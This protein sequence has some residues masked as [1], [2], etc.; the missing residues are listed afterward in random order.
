MY[1]SKQRCPRPKHILRDAPKPK[2]DDHEWESVDESSDD[3]QLIAPERPDGYDGALFQQYPITDLKMMMA[4]RNDLGMTKGKI[5]AQ[6]GH[7]TLGAY[8]KVKLWA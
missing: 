8:K 3:D 7:A 4:V 6:C 1:V 5:G 2:S